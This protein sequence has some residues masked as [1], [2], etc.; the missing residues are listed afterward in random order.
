MDLVSDWQGTESVNDA[1][2]Q[3]PGLRVCWIIL[4]GAENTGCRKEVLRDDEEGSL[5]CYLEYD[6]GLLASCLEPVFVFF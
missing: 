2:K 3:E 4:L 5:K 1:G 6:Q